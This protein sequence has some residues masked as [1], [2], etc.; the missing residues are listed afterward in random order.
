MCQRCFSF[1]FDPPRP[2]R[3]PDPSAR[4]PPTPLT[5]MQAGRSLFDRAYRNILTKY[6]VSV[7]STPCRG[8]LTGFAA[9]Q[10]APSGG[11]FLLPYTSP[12]HPRLSPRTAGR[13]EEAAEITAG[14]SL[15]FQAHNRKTRRTTAKGGTPKNSLSPGSKNIIYISLLLFICQQTFSGSAGTRFR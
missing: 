13:V 11:Q 10:F 6:W 9:L 15:P 14:A 4:T 1:Y 12:K 5:P 7:T 8:R 3:Q 2:T